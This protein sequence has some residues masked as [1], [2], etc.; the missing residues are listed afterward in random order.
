MAV[1]LFASFDSGFFF[2]FSDIQADKDV[3]LLDNGFLAQ[4][5]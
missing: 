2:F 5:C 3:P 4:V 1:I